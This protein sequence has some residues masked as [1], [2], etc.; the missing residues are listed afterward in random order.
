MNTNLPNLPDVYSHFVKYNETEE[1]PQST[2]ER[3]LNSG[4]GLKV[5][6]PSTDDKDFYE[7]KYIQKAESIEVFQN[8]T[9]ITDFKPKK[10]PVFGYTRS[11]SYPSKEDKAILHRLNTIPVFCVVTGQGE[12]VISSPRSV[13][14]LNFFTWVYE[15]YFNNFI[16][17]GDKGPINIALYFMH[18]E[19][20]ELYLHEVCVQ[21][22]QGA[23][24]YG[25]KVQASG[26]DNYYHLSKTAPPR[27][28]VRLVANLKE[29]DL[30]IKKHLK[31]KS[32]SKWP[33]QRYTSD[34]FKGT[35]IYL[36]FDQS[37]HMIL[38]FFNKEDVDSHW[39]ESRQPG[40]RKKPPIEIYNL[41]G[42]LSYMQKSGMEYI[43]VVS[44][45][46]SSESVS[47]LKKIHTQE[48][49]RSK[50]ND[51]FN[52]IIENNLKPKIVS[53]Q[54][55]CKGMIWLITSEELPTEENSW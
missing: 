28:Q 48:P 47:I 50:I 8:P 6:M 7:S 12:I 9:S 49:A 29:V 34:G 37:A 30:V 27:T 19:D 41:E 15:K 13:K 43:E 45:V 55:F 46:S 3:M 54:R 39:Q 35:P 17:I 25:I 40:Q 38:A 11:T 32:F 20:A 31:D 51:N 18:K 52:K 14:P 5:N 36:T 23:Q 21:D 42:F 33:T 4:K 1:N 44:F 10:M 16:W 26:L 22:P 24:R 2:F 53:L